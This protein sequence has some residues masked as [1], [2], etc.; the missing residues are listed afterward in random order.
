[1]QGK[2]Y[3]GLKQMKRGNFLLQKVRS[4]RQLGKRCESTFCKKIQKV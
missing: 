1:M 3:K 4:A 2:D